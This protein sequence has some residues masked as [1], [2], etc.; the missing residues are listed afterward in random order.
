MLLTE[1][2]PSDVWKFFDEIVRIPRSSGHEEKIRDYLVDFA[3]HRNFDC[4][5]DEC[6]S[7]IID[8][9]ATD[10]KKDAPFVILQGHMD[11]VP[12]VE[13]G[14]THDFMN[15]GIDA[16]IEDGFVKAH[17]TTLGADNGIAIAMALEIFDDKD[18]SH[19]PLRGIFT[20]EEET[21]MKGAINLDKKYLNADYLINLDSEENGYLYV[22]CAGSADINIRF[23]VQK[24]E[25]EDCQALNFE[26]SGFTGGH[27]GTDIANGNANT[28]KVLASI[29][30]NLSDDFDFFIQSIDGGFVRNSIPSSANV[31]AAVPKDE[32][33]AFKEAFIQCFNEQK[34]IYKDTDKN[35]RLAVKEEKLTKVL[36]YAQSLDL[37]HLLRSLPSGII[38]MSSRFEGIVETSVN[39]G[40]VRSADESINICLLPRSLNKLALYDLIKAVQAQCYLLDNADVEVDNEHEPWESPNK[41]RLIDVLNQTSVEV[42]GSEF[43]I[44]AMHA[45]VECAS[46]AKANESLQLVSIG[47]DLFNPHSVAERVSIEGTARI[48]EIVRRALAIL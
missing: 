6:G 48:F 24:I 8:V 40:T 4:T 42:T 39:L 47:P 19:G 14:Y 27:S 16:Y 22:N 30:D 23:N 43:K 18:L 28:I 7:V 26:L 25:V 35:C 38:R 46:F 1:L 2:S 45:G 3:R 36:S 13:D 5:V 34:K 32:I 41:N 12:V 11:M 15:E 44:T 29:L 17:H 10:D 20:V 21:T 31:T 9:P 33:K 37:I